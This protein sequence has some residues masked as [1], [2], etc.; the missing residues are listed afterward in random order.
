MLCFFSI[1]LFHLTDPWCM[2]Y[3]RVR[4]S[5]SSGTRRRSQQAVANHCANSITHFIRSIVSRAD[6]FMTDCTQSKKF[7]THGTRRE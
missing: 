5:G 3:G 2:L 7:I 4:A 1:S 6:V